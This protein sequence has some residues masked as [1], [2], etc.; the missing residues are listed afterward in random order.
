MRG[1][2]PRIHPFYEND[3]LPD[4]AG[5]GDLPLLRP[6]AGLPDFF[7]RR[8]HVEMRSGAAWN[9]IGDGVHDRGD[10]CGGARFARTLHAERVGR[11]RHR[12]DGVLERGHVVGARHR[13]IHERAGDQLPARAVEH[14]V[15]HHRLAQALGDGAVG[16]PLDD[17]GVERAA[18]I[19][20][21]GIGHEHKLAG[22]R[23]DLHLGDVTAV[24]KCQRRFRI[25]LGI[26][27][28]GDFAALFH[29]LGAGGEI[30]QGDAAIGPHHAETPVAVFDVAFGRF[31]HVCSDRLAPGQQRF[32]GLDQRMA[33]GH[34]GA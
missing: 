15:L 16:L 25:D 28:F 13:V 5:N 32:D 7:R 3:G 10:R 29:F 26:E 18:A 34:R 24:G 21:R 8:W 27:V 11:R 19:V 33:H 31:Q 22:L 1:L 30:E 2:R 17:H 12:M 9:G 20:D 4:Q 23:I 14:R 6:S